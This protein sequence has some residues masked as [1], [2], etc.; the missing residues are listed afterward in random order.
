MRPDSSTTPDGATR[1]RHRV[2]IAALLG[3]ALML[4]LCI[5]GANIIDELEREADQRNQ[6]ADVVNRAQDAAALIS[7]AMN[8]R[9]NLTSG[10]AAFVSTHEVIDADE[11][12]RFA[13]L[14]RSNLDAIV[15]LQLAPNGVV[16]YLTD[17]E[18]NRAALGHDLFADPRRRPTV[19]RSI[20]ERRYIIAG[21]IKLIQGG[22]AVI[23]RKPIFLDHDGGE[24]FWG[25]ATV[26]IDVGELLSEARIGQLL[27]DYRVAL[28]GRDGRGARGGLFVGDPSTFDDALV[29]EDIP[30]PDASWQIAFA[31][32]P[33]SRPPV[34]IG[35]TTYYLLSLLIA[36]LAAIATYLVLDRRRV[37]TLEVLRATRALTEEVRQRQAA[38]DKMRYVAQHDALT[39]LPNRLLFDELAQQLLA[40]ARRESRHCA[41]LF[42]DIDGFKPVNDSFGHAAGDRLLKQIAE[43]LKGRVRES[44]LVSRFGGDEFVI[45]LS[46]DCDLDRACALAGQVLDSLAVSFDLDGHAVSVGA[47]IGIAVFPIH[48]ETIA[49][50]IKRA[51]AAMYVAKHEGKGRYRVAD[52]TLDGPQHDRAAQELGA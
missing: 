23:A 24:H 15:S 50:L 40:V 14:L 10:L 12:E 28:R 31:P 3:A 20:R 49:T 32:K 11:F 8:V 29:I 52:A 35:S 48:G 21:P 17:L 19:E 6:H 1:S 22:E 43:R 44:D 13:S 34:F 27:K 9:L 7:S 41:V 36:V 47:S 38:E 18:R 4:V 51:D 5:V 33:G 30:L 2:N 45:M 39:D 37:L 26:L 46:S 16:T 25:F 42:A